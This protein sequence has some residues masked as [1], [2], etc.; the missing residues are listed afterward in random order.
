[1]ENELN[2]L[3]QTFAFHYEMAQAI[4]EKLETLWKKDK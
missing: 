1:M 2:R 4:I 3:K